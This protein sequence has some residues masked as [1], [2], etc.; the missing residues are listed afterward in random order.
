MRRGMACVPLIIVLPLVLAEGCQEE[1]SVEEQAQAGLAWDLPPDAGTMAGAAMLVASSSNAGSPA[2]RHER[3]ALV[4]RERLELSLLLT[5]GTDLTAQATFTS[6]QPKAATVE[7]NG[8]TGVADGITRVCGESGKHRACEDFPV[9]AYITTKFYGS[10][11]NQ[12]W[13]VRGADGHV[14]LD[15][16]GNEL[17]PMIGHLYTDSQFSGHFGV[18]FVAWTVYDFRDGAE[19]SLPEWLPSGPTN[20]LRPYEVQDHLLVVYNDESAGL[21]RW[22][23]AQQPG[24]EATGPTSVP[25]PPGFKTL[26]WDVHL[27]LP[28]DGAFGVFVA[29]DADGNLS[30]VY[31]PFPDGQAMVLPDGFS[32]TRPAVAS[33]T[34]RF[35]VVAGGQEQ[36]TWLRVYQGGAKTPELLFEKEVLPYPLEAFGVTFSPDESQLLLRFALC[37]GDQQ[38]FC[39]QAWLIDIA[40]QEETYLPAGAQF[41]PAGSV[42]FPSDDG[43]FWK[44]DP[45]T[46]EFGETRIWAGRLPLH[47]SGEVTPFGGVDVPV[48]ISD[49]AYTAQ[50]EGVEQIFLR[51]LPIGEWS[52]PPAP[53]VPDDPGSI[54]VA[55]YGATG[56]PAILPGELSSAALAVTDRDGANPHLVDA[57]NEGIVRYILT[58]NGQIFLHTMSGRILVTDSTGTAR[59]TL[60]ANTSDLLAAAPDGRRVAY[61]AGRDWSSP[62]TRILEVATG[63]TLFSAEDMLYVCIPPGDAPIFAVTTSGQALRIDTTAGT[64]KPLC[65][66]ADRLDVLGHTPLVSIPDRITCSLDAKRVAYVDADKRLFLLDG[67]TGVSTQVKG[68]E[69]LDV[70]RV[71]LSGDGDT[72]A[73]T[74]SGTKIN[75]IGSEVPRIQL[76]VG[77]A[78]DFKLSRRLDYVSQVGEHSYHLTKPYVSKGGAEVSLIFIDQL[79]H[80]VSGDG[81]QMLTIKLISNLLRYDVGARSLTNLFEVSNGHSALR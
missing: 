38:G 71:G 34:G 37:Y 51:W 8:L 74:V 24:Q 23:F 31:T 64:V 66:L 79:T 9:A 63:D 60:A 30:N 1:L 47:P 27:L 78:P 18:D 52:S 53:A 61:S 50:E 65:S 55:P 3:H 45:K 48:G 58:D 12:V 42:L 22:G 19:V 25:M 68:A 7:G 26:P 2:N 77:R 72:L 17:Y 46:G 5:D 32:Q 43:C 57:G 21:F 39:G 75:N 41:G 6:S 28:A 13:R 69:Q 73:A 20:E 44:L 14:A 29:Q 62:V 49:D 70:L 40:T 54:V 10:D 80:L 59:H 33:K 35:A 56:D 36:P 15:E 81:G 67:E 76:W 4:P 11:Q 16:A